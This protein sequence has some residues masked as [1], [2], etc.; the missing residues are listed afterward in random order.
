MYLRCYTSDHP[1]TW[2]N[3]LPW[4]KFWY[5]TA[6]QTAAKMTLFEVLYG[7]PPPTVARYVRDTSSNALVEAQ[8]VERDQVLQVLKENLRRAQNRMKLLANRS[9]C[10]VTFVEG[11]WVYVKLQPFRQHSIRLQRHHKLS[12]RYFGPYKVIG[13]VGE[14]AYKLELPESAHIHPV[15][16][17]SLLK[18]C[19]GQPDQQVT[20]L[21]LA[22]S[23]SALILQPTAILEMRSIQ[24]ANSLIEQWLVQW[25]DSSTDEATWEDKAYMLKLFPDLNLKDKV[26]L[27]VGGNVVNDP[28]RQ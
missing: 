20:P 4:A 1:S 8:L 15:F 21:H 9:R 5:N 16:H 3:M 22:D 19:L 26:C 28:P 12:R 14:V 11:V 23:T 25:D 18:K 6:Y 7:R 17:V 24:R 27:D 13:R 2:T 10:E